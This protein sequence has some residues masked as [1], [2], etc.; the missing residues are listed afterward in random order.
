M[1]GYWEREM[2]LKNWVNY[3]AT[4]RMNPPIR[5]EVHCPSSK[6]TSPGEHTGNHFT[7]L[8]REIDDVIEIRVPCSHQHACVWV[9]CVKFKQKNEIIERSLVLQEFSANRRVVSVFNQL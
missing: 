2:S 1:G 8:A 6:R 9:S 5:D 4:A 3:N 7:I